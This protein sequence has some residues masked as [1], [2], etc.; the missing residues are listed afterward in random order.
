MGFDTILA[1][2]DLGYRGQPFNWVT[3][4]D[5]FT[6]AAL[7]RHL[8]AD[9]GA[10]PLV[11]Q[12][13]LI[14]S[15]APWVPVP[16]LVPWE[17]IGDGR[18]FDAMAAAGD[19]P[20]VVWRDR[21]RVRAQYAKAVDY[22]LSAVLAYAERHAAAPPLILVLGDHQAAPFV[23]Q[24]ARWDVPAHLIG[25]PH[26]VA[27]AAGWGWAPGLIPPAD[28]PAPGMEVMRDRIL[29]AWSTGAPRREA[30]R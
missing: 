30:L 9:P 5:Q 4:P 12:V 20:D 25:P 2:K 15:H 14:S 7:D 24:D 19:P 26:L 1:A 27:A 11:A 23:A 21:D 13:A 3:M 6:L 17:E 28:A 10:R 16:A 29:R 18:V 22:A 8:R